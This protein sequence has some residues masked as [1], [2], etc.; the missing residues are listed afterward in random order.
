METWRRELEQRLVFY[1]TVIT[2]FSSL[3]TIELALLCKLGWD[4]V[5]SFKCVVFP[6]HNALVKQCRSDNK[7]RHAGCYRKAGKFSNIFSRQWE[8]V[9]WQKDD[10]YSPNISLSF[11]FCFNIHHRKMRWGH[12]N[13][14]SISHFSAKWKAGSMW[15]T[16]QRRIGTSPLFTGEEN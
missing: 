2:L 5:L 6:L 16:D 15:L 8:N 11:L 14:L 3:I 10:R 9:T 1:Y 13:F 12:F 4:C 7:I